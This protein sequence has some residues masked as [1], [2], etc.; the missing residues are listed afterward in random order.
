VL[1][2]PETLTSQ[3]KYIEIILTNEMSMSRQINEQGA[4]GGG[5]LCNP[6][7]RMRGSMIGQ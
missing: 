6:W 1:I 5:A 7:E 4:T 2:E 3:S